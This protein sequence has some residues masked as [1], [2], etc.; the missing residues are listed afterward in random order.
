M[1]GS[2]VLW[3]A[4][5]ILV[6]WAVGVYKRITRLRARGFD[7]FG[8]LEK[9]LKSF[10]GLLQTH[11]LAPPVAAQAHGTPFSA[12]S[13][14]VASQWMALIASVQALELACKAARSASLMPAEVAALGRAMDVVSGQWRKLCDGPLDLAGSPVPDA[15]RVQWDEL[16]NKAQAARAA[17]NQILQRYNEALQDFPARLIVGLLGFHAT[18]T[19]S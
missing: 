10:S 18:G 9:L 7:A 13:L 11:V 1:G 12:D 19:L 17:L 5:A 4:V 14:R 3:M 6:S 15:L 8:S 16:S 2:I